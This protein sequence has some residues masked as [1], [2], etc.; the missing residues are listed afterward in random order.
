MALALLHAPDE[1]ACGGRGNY[2]PEPGQELEISFLFS[3]CLLHI[4]LY[5]QTSVL[6]FSW[7]P[8][9]VGVEMEAEG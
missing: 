1:S 6:P 3:W 4:H 7:S 5:M 8:A 9:Q 2:Y